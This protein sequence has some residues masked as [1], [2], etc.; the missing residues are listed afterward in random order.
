M[1]S[2][3]LTEAI[4]RSRMDSAPH[5][6]EILPSK[7]SKWRRFKIALIIVVL[8]I[9]GY[10]GYVLLTGNKPVTP[11]IHTEETVP[12]R[13]ILQIAPAE[14]IISSKGFSPQT[15]KI[16][17]GQAVE[18]TNKDRAQH[19]LV[20]DN[21]SAKNKTGFAGQGPLK[22]SEEFLFTFFETGTY[23]YNDKLNSEGFRGIVIVE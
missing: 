1:L 11:L 17:K 9:T 21:Y 15:V 13:E 6:Q 10:F 5:T 19:Q 20:S 7:R 4:E 14:V 23:G 8:G 22:F 16:K 18:W 12:S 3:T 2:V